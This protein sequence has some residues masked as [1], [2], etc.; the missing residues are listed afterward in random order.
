MTMGM[1]FLTLVRVLSTSTQRAVG[2]FASDSCG[3]LCDRLLSDCS[4]SEKAFSVRKS[5]STTQDSMI[6]SKERSYLIELLI[7]LTMVAGMPV[8]MSCESAHPIE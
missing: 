1:S 6:A 4:V 8:A 3:R 5:K 2:T 7:T